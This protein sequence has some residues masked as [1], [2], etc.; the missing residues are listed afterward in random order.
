MIARLTRR[1]KGFALI[2][3]LLV[4]VV[5]AILWLIVIP[6]LLEAGRKAKEARMKGALHDLR[7]AIQQFEAD[8]GDYPSSLE[9]LMAPKGSCPPDGGNGI[10][11]DPKTYKG[12]YID[13]IPEN[14]FFDEKA[15]KEPEEQVDLG[16]WRYNRKTG[17]LHSWA[18][19]TALDGHTTYDTW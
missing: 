17:D 7:N 2:E 14:P 13:R 5:I 10:A 4:I 15:T 16:G 19:A 11:I 1:S 8:C 6:R 9:D 18:T 3:V 12:P